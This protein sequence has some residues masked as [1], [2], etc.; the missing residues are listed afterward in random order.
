MRNIATNASKWTA[1]RPETANQNDCRDQRSLDLAIVI[2]N[3]KDVYPTNPIQPPEIWTRPFV[4][5]IITAMSASTLRAIPRYR[6]DRR[7]I[8][9][10]VHPPNET[11][12]Y[13]PLTHMRVAGSGTIPFGTLAFRNSTAHCGRTIKLCTAAGITTA[14]PLANITG[15]RPCTST[16]PQPSTATSI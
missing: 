9:N 1:S 7:T 3:S 14:S 11:L 8:F 10:S 5:M 13:M 15:S 6:K 16:A 12:R 4:R 2:Q